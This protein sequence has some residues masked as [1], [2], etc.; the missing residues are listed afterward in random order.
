MNWDDREEAALMLFR[1]AILSAKKN[2]EESRRCVHEALVIL[3]LECPTCGSIDV[4]EEG[5]CKRCVLELSDE[6]GM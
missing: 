2:K 1:T 5:G 6:C 4:A 3:G